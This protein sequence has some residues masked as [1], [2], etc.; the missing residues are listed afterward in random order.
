[1]EH[2]KESLGSNPSYK[3]LTVNFLKK[4]YEVNFL[5]LIS[6]VRAGAC[7]I[8]APMRGRVCA[9]VVSAI[10]ARVRSRGFDYR[11]AGRV[12]VGAWHRLGRAG[13]AGARTG[14]GLYR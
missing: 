5:K 14:A 3:F 1:M 12:R 7:V 11:G 13:S 9:C 2:S 4:I 8:V 10:W 6:K